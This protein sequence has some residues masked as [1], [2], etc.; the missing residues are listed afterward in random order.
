M[1]TS[2]PRFAWE[3]L[4]DDLRPGQR[5][6]QDAKRPCRIPTQSVGTSFFIWPLV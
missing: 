2:F 6:E 4:G 3:H 1:A 5:T